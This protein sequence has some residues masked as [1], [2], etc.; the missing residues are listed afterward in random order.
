MIPDFHE[1][2]ESD[3]YPDNTLIVMENQY[4]NSGE[5]GFSIDEE[6]NTEPLTYDDK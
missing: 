4:Y 1:K 2:L 6:G 3:Y 5:N